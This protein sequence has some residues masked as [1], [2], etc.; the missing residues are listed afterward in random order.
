MLGRVFKDVNTGISINRSFV[1][2]C[3]YGVRVNSGIAMGANYA[4]I[5]YGGVAVK[6][7]I[8]MTP[9]MRVCATARPMRF[10]R[11]LMLARAPSNY[12][13]IHQA[14]TLPIV[15]RSNY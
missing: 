9:G 14:F 11:Q 2:S 4:F 5:S 12:G 6:G 7:G 10:G 3:K 13:C 15:V 8:L 1:Y